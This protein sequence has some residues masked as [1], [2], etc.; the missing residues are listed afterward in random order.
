[1]NSNPSSRQATPSHPDVKDPFEYE[2][3][4]EEPKPCVHFSELTAGLRKNTKSKIHLRTETFSEV[5]E[6]APSAG[7]K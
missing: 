4:K 1:M 5:D 2:R 7:I 3:K 6:S